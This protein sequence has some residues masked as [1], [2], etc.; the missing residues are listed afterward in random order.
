MEYLLIAGC[1]C[2]FILACY[3]YGKLGTYTGWLQTGQLPPDED[4][5]TEDAQMEMGG[6]VLAVLVMGALIAAIIVFMN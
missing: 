3:F 1:I 5:E 4:I 2:A 6:Y